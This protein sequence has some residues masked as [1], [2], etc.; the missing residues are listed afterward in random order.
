MVEFAGWDMPVEYSGITD[1][2]MAVRTRA[3]LFDVS[4]MGEIEVAG[5]DALTFVQWITT[6]D[7]SRL[8][9]GQ[10]QYSALTT[11]EGTFVDDVLVYRLADEH[12]LLV[13]NAGSVAKAWAWIKSQAAE[14]GGDVA[15]VNASARYALIAVQGPE[16]ANITQQLTSVDLQG[17]KYY[18]FATGEVAS[19]RATISRTGYTGEDGFELFVPPADASRV[20]RA[21]IEAGKSVDIRPCGLGARDTLRLEAGMRLSGSDMDEHTT[22]LE[23]GL[24]WLIGWKKDHFVGDAPLRAQKAGGLTRKLVA[25]E[26]TERAIARHGHPVMSNGAPCGVVTSGTQTP[27]LKKAIGL[28]MVPMEL[29]AV[30]TRLDIDVRG[31][32]CSAM[33]VAE[34]FYK[35]P[36]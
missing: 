11:P 25:F 22:V 32:S 18:W 29:T 5:T 9:V 3:G 34:P 28:A 31:R 1:E 21:L 7:A 26:M 13:V 17:I 4:H 14:A 33:V 15:L 36:R 2:H 24:G 30:G 12:Y 6:N 10:A 16:A 20:W 19:V 27:F 8:S 35:R 23:A